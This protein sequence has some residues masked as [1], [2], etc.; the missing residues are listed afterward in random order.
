MSRDLSQAAA[1][2]TAAADAVRHKGK[3][4]DA[5]SVRR[6]PFA[7]LHVRALRDPVQAAGRA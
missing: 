5:G 4:V 7:P 3:R 6:R 2:R 1:S